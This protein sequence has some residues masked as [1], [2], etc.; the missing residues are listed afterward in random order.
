MTEEAWEAL[1]AHLRE[2]HGK[3]K[4][5]PVKGAPRYLV[6]KTDDASA[7]RIR[8]EAPEL[9]AGDARVRTLLTSGSIGKLKRR[10][11]DGTGRDN[12]KVP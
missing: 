1:A 4:A 2:R 3:A 8:E 11:A 6:V 5:I 9:R 10:A 12:G 7:P